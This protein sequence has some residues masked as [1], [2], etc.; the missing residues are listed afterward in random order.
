MSFPP[1][2][3]NTSFTTLLFRNMVCS[4]SNLFFLRTAY[5]ILLPYTGT[6]YSVDKNIHI[7]VLCLPCTILESLL[8]L[9]LLFFCIPCT[10]SLYMVSCSFRNTGNQYTRFLPFYL[11]LRFLACLKL[12]HPHIRIC[13]PAVAANVGFFDGGVPQYFPFFQRNYHISYMN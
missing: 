12:N 2:L 3:Q 10:S 7:Q 8:N 5:T 4:F 1:N 9:I 6:F 11:S 13:V